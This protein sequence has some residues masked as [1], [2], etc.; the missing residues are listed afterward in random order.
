MPN[1][2]DLIDFGDYPEIYADGLG[3]VQITG[4]NARLLF[5]RW[6]KMDGVFRRQIASAI[7]RPVASLAADA[8]VIEMAKR[9][10]VALPT[11]GSDECDKVTS[12]Q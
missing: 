4:V 8:F 10:G 9:E 1:D 6:R 7:T 12:L 5:F 11:S 3:E 2:N